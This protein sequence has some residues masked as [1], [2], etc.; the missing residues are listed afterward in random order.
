MRKKK[1]ASMAQQSSQLRR[2]DTIT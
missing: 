2:S 1:E